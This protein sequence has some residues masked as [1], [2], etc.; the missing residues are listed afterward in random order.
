MKIMCNVNNVC[1]N[2]IMIIILIIIILM[3]IILLLI[4][5]ILNNIINNNNNDNIVCNIKLCVWSNI[6]KVILMCVIM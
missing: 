6:D 4:L 5:L 1:I 2:I 3:I